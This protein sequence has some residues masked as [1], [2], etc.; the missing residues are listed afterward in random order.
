MHVQAY[1]YARGKL[2][3]VHRY[4]AIRSVP[5]FPGAG[6]VW[7]DRTAEGIGRLPGDV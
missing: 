5:D 1:A 6:E 4:T 2:R 3:R 7:G